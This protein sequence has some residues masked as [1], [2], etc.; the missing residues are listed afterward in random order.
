VLL[1]PL[2]LVY[3]LTERLLGSAGLADNL[4]LVARRE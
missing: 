2:R 4:I 3:G 1:L